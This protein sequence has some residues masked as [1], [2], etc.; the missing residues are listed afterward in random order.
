MSRVRLPVKSQPVRRLPLTPCPSRQSYRNAEQ[1]ANGLRE[2][3]EDLEQRL[4]DDQRALLSTRTQSESQRKES[5]QLLLTVFQNLNKILG[6]DVR[7]P[8][9]LPASSHSLR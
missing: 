6:T 5:S 1:E 9:E 3:V 8:A 4:T 2:R 7:R